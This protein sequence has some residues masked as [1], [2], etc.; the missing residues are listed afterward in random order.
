[1]DIPPTRPAAASP[2]LMQKAHA[3]E[4]VFLAEMLKHAAPMPE[5][6]AFGGGHGEAQFR[7]FLREEQARLMADA[8]GLGLAEHL[9]RSLAKL[10][11]E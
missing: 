9:Y 3:L 7:S 1:M 6:G 11:A 10:G 4:A 2:V 8:G 5:P